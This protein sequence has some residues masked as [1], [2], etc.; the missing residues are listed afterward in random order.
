MSALYCRSLVVVVCGC[1]RLS[2]PRIALGLGGRLAAVSVW[3]LS[4]SGDEVLWC[5]FVGV[6]GGVVEVR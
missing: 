4:V 5:R 2:W 1:P 3:E 6:D